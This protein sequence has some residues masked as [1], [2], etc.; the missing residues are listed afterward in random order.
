MSFDRENLVVEFVKLKDG[1]HDFCLS[2]D[3]GFFEL[4]ENSEILDADL[5][6]NVHLE[7]LVNW[8]H[9]QLEISGFIQQECG[10]CLEPLNL[11]VSSAY[12][13]IY[14]LN[15]EEENEQREFEDDGVELVYLL[16]AAT[17]FDMSQAAYETACLGL[18]MLK[19]CDE[20]E[21]KPCNNQMIQ[22]LDELNQKENQENTNDPRWDKLKDLFK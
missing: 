5:L 19:N 22:K 14:R 10:R 20:M 3:K 21:E 1:K 15:S 2:L 6:M 4:F 13:L 16:P 17:Q 11:P 12:K 7:K 9:V 8:I 18:P